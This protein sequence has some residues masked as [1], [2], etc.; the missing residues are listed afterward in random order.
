MKKSFKEQTNF[1]QRKAEAERI[2]KKYPDRIPVI[3]ERAKDTSLPELDKSKYL[4]PND[5]TIGQ[6]I[7]VIRNRIKLKPEKAIYIF[8]NNTI[9]PTSSLMSRIYNEYMNEDGFL[10]MQITSENTFGSMPIC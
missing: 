4:V 3:V 10:Y 8:I 9:P 2:R 6:F 7:Y 5:I 1:E